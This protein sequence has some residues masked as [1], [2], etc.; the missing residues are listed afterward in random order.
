[1]LNVS[2][3]EQLAEKVYGLLE[4]VGMK[5]ENDTVISIMTEKG[6]TQGPD[7]RVRIPR[8]LIDEMAGFQKKTQAADADDQQLHHLCGIDWAHFIIWHNR[9]NEMREKLKT[10]FQMSA[11]DCGPTKYYDY[12]QR[13]LRAVDTEVFIEANKFVQATDEIGYISSWYRQDVSPKIERLDSLVL[14]LQYNEKVA[15]TE[16]IYPEVIKYLAEISRIITEKP[17]DHSYL[18]GSEC[19]T[20]PLI[21][22]KRS[23]ADILARKDNAVHRYHVASMPT[24]GISTPVAIAGSVVM[25]A[26][27]VLAGMTACWC[28]DPESDLSGRMVAAVVDMRSAGSHYIGP[29]TTLVNLA[30]RELFDTYWG[31]HLW[32]EIF[33]SPH[34][35]QPGMQ[36]VYENLLGGWRAAKLLGKADITYPGMGALGDGGVG[37]PVQFVL[38]M[39]IRKAQFAAAES[40]E[41]DDENLLF[42]E[43]CRVVS[44]GGE[45]LT[46]EHTLGH[47]RQLWSSD[48]LLPIELEGIDEA[49]I[50]D[51]C[52]Q[53][54]VENLKKYEPPQWPKEKMRAM[55]DVL[56]R[57]KKE[58]L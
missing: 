18:A 47:F 45:F 50:L 54:C 6:C 8:G 1:M 56:A 24:I 51:K 13:K 9:Q 39:E 10:T 55:N 21:L 3:K 34:T 19:M 38:D 12:K 22:E 37:S 49:K 11:F 31:G 36:A 52:R 32:V 17:G 58:L 4:T 28:V 2:R 41:V 46:S 43:I 42:D 48:I 27:E 5:V 57:A 16:A 40:F 33:L 35:Q 25:C 23:A 44:E 7:G 26:A 30:V 29:E 14:G 20:M 53:V 15:G